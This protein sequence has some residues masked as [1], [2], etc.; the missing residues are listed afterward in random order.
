MLDFAA[1]WGDRL[2]SSISCNLDC[3]V[4]VDPNK[5]LM[6]GHNSIIKMFAPNDIHKYKI[7]YEPFQSCE[8]PE[9]QT[10]DLVFT[11]P[12]FFDLEIYNNEK[13]QS[14]IDFPRFEDW[15]VHFLFKSLHKAWKKLDKDG[16]MA[17]HISDYGKTS[18]CEVM[19]L[20]VQSNLEGA[21]YEGVVASLGAAETQR[22]IWVWKKISAENMD[23][24][25][26]ERKK[27]AKEYLTTYYTDINKKIEE[28]F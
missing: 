18:C 9:N 22:P 6:D 17:I 7:I 13:G 19:N 25:Q 26:L 16:H 11:S 14:V 27:K 1:G 12:P 28:H 10:F 3:Y 8:L 15:I 2:I 24:Q 21:V 4:G 20:F 23:E 5:E